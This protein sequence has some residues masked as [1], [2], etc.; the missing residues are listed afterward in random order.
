MIR[1]S[2][3]YAMIFLF[4]LCIKELKYGY[5]NVCRNKFRAVRIRRIKSN[6][7]EDSLLESDSNEKQ[8][9]YL[10]YKY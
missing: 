2:M 3:N 9:I 7:F 5:Q 1:F 4:V 8:L 10:M 6:R